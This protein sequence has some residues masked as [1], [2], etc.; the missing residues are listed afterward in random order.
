MGQGIPVP[1]VS[2]RFRAEAA[3]AQMG[4]KRMVPPDWR[5]VL[6]KADAS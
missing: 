6:V 4:K 1:F 5:P 2:D 3:T